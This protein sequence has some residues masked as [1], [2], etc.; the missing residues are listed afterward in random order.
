MAKIMN[1]ASIKN[2]A[3]FI[4]SM[5]AFVIPFMGSA[6]NIALPSIG[7]EFSMDAISLGW[8]ATSYLLAVAV[9]L[10]PVGRFAD[11]Y[12]RKKIFLYGVIFFSLTCALLGIVN[13]A[14]LLIILRMLQGIS[15]AMIFGTATAVAVIL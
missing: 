12:G 9:T 15:A 7:R 4:A 10:V 1:N 3:L 13:S 11:I 6:I 5:T 2:T 8:V 14:P